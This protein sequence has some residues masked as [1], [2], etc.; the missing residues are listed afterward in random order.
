MWDGIEMR[1][2]FGFLKGGCIFR[3]YNVGTRS[4]RSRDSNIL[5]LLE[6]Q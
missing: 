4:G 6:E 5:A 1:I 2:V 3:V